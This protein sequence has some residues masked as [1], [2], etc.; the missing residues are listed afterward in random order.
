M[1]EHDKLYDDALKRVNSLE[2]ELANLEKNLDNCMMSKNE[3]LSK[4]GST[5]MLTKGY[6]QGLEK[7]KYELLVSERE[8]QSERNTAD[9]VLRKNILEWGARMF[10]KFGINQSE[11]NNFLDCLTDLV[12]RIRQQQR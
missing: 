7:D 1:E 5:E 12:V 8:K 4:E 11:N 2:G 3:I 6:Y 9:E 10:G